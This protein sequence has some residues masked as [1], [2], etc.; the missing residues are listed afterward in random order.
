MSFF[1]TI[2]ISFGFGVGT[3]IL[4]TYLWKKRPKKRPVSEEQITR[5]IFRCIARE[6]GI[7]FEQVNK[8]TILEKFPS[9]VFINLILWWKGEKPID[10]GPGITVKELLKQLEIHV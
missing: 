10:A 2:V 3:G 4:V 8:D 5:S 7:P 6:E 1:E 9:F